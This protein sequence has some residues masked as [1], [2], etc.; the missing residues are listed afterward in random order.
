[1]IDFYFKYWYNMSTLWGVDMDNINLVEWQRKCLEDI[2][3]KSCV[4]LS[5]PTGSGKTTV[6]EKWAFGKKERPIFITAPIKALSNHRYR[7]L[8]SKGYKVGLE[9]GDVSYF[10]DDNCD[11]ICCTQEIYNYKYRNL[12][13][14]T[15]II[16]E[17]SYIYDDMDRSRAYI[18]S[19]MYSKAANIMLCSATFGNSAEVLDY[20]RRVS[21]RDFYLFENNERLTSLEYKGAIPMSRIHDSFVVAYSKEDCYL[22][23]KKLYQQRV[24][25]IMS[26]S[27]GYDPRN[28]YR[29]KIKDLANRYEIK[30]NELIEFALMGVVY[31]CGKLYPKE[32]LFVEELLE[33]RYVDSV[34]G[35]NALALGVNFPIESV[36]FSALKSGTGYKHPKGNGSVISKNLFEQLSGRAGRKKYFDKGYVYYCDEFYG[37][38]LD[39]EFWDL[40]RKP[41]IDF[42]VVLGRDI[43]AILAGEI[44]V[45]EDTLLR[46]RYST[47]LVDEEKM[48]EETQKRI[49][50]IKELDITKFYFRKVYGIDISDGFYSAISGFSDERQWEL[51]KMSVKLGMSQSLFERDIGKVYMSEYSID[52]NC[53]LF[54]DVLIGTSLERLL[55]VNCHSFKSGD[56]DV[57]PLL[58]F[59][60]YMKKLPEEYSQNYDLSVIDNLINSI[61]PTILEPYRYVSTKNSAN[62]EEKAKEPEKK[63]TFSIDSRKR[64]DI[65]RYK[66]NKY[67]KMLI[68]GDKLLLCDYADEGDLRLNYIPL[69]SI[70][71]VVDFIGANKLAEMWPRIDFSSFGE[72]GDDTDRYKQILVSDN[73]SISSGPKLTKRKKQIQTGRKKRR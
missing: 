47:V 4:I 3:G 46:A 33:H 71:T 59:R 55:K 58:D 48:T 30:N 20:V 69:Q 40:V 56:Y 52:R 28:R 8:C 17:F 53:A 73:S 65:V 22:L 42:Q 18:D 63:E 60:K 64:F 45:E 13:N 11:V 27:T 34:V 50:Y 19:L 25:A 26:L 57:K 23:A 2:D 41:N 35:T 38:S 15:V 36:V 43:K 66:N 16:D 5:S 31:Y 44:T 37:Y 70:Y 14:A 32:K 72:L 24:E 51:E 68:E 67:V 21:G 49:D 54:I 39:K 6:Y 9:T 61:D 29:G 10:P 1:M 62:N 7:D 12:R